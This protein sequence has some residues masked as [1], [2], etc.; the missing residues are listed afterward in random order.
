[1]LCGCVN[2]T[3]MTFSPADTKVAAMFWNSDTAQV[4]EIGSVDNPYEGT[5]ALQIKVDEEIV[6]D[7]LACSP[8]VVADYLA[9]N[10]SRDASHASEF[11]S[12]P[13]PRSLRSD[14]IW[15][16]G[17]RQIDFL[18]PSERVT[19][20]AYDEARR[21]GIRLI[22]QNGKIKAIR[23]VDFRYEPKD[24]MIQIKIADSPWM[25][26]RM[27]EQACTNLFGKVDKK[28]NYFTE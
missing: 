22:A 1:M 10:D 12:H 21:Q 4:I 18:N 16:E 7:S 26:S 5:P 9:E 13:S 8:D 14:N 23:I 17:A 11:G 24:H 6:F 3:E 19:D 20:L 27:D 25:D 2:T 15:G 28:I